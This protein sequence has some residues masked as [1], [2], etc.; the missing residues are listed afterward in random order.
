MNEIL[1]LGQHWAAAEQRGDTDTLDSITTDDFTLVGPLG[2]VLAKPA[3]LERYRTGGLVTRSLAWEDTTVR[4]YG[5]TAVV[6]GRHTQQAEFRGTPVNGSFRA[7]HILVRRDGTWL[8]AGIHLSPIAPPVRKAELNHTIVRA[9]DKAASAAFLARI[10]G[11]AMGE[12]AGPFVPV[13]LTNGVTLDFMDVGTV[14]CQ[15]YAFLID[16]AEFDAAFARIREFGTE[17]WADP[18]RRRPGETN[19]M[20][21]GRGV[22]FADPD[23]HNMELMTRG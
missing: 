8:L 20:N 19:T 9:S 2:F 11:L 17:Y 6:V 21:G 12:P 16:E 15:H 4:D 14:A 18:D 3:W 5:D 13:Q 23:G 10:L 1:Q 22:Y 7:T